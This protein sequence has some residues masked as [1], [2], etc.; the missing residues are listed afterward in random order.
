MEINLIYKDPRLTIFFFIYITIESLN[1]KITANFSLIEKMAKNI[2][3]I[4]NKGEKAKQEKGIDWLPFQQK[5]VRQHRAFGLKSDH[6]LS[7]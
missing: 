6:S 3:A 2:C 7:C 5:V 4:V 1:N